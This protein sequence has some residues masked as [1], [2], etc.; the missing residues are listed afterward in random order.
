[1]VPRAIICD[2]EGTTSAISFVHKVLFPLSLERLDAYLSAHA[3]DSEVAAR[4]S[5][6][7]KQLGQG[8]A[9]P[10]DRLAVLSATLKKYIRDDVKDT[11]LKW[12]QGKIWK[13]AFEAGAIKGHVYGEVSE[14]FRLW[15]SS[16]YAL[17]IYSSGS[18][19]AQQLVFKY[20][21]AGDL[22]VFIDGY[23]DT[24][25]GMKRETASY[26]KI[27]VATGYLPAEMLFLSDI[28]EELNAAAGAGMQTCLLLR[29][30]AQPPAGYLDKTAEN[31]TEVH[32]QF[33]Q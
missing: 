17:F 29:E 28:V 25:T 4:L 22:T 33:F 5:A 32:R 24:N 9:S 8:G 19:E 1:M 26:E 20:S 12:L 10:V 16:G 11:T 13:Q 31:F 30:S 23:F 2:I 21:E 27:A 15:K 7:E 3:G 6:L 18:V 14:Y